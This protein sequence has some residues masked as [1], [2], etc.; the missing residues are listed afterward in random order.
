MN[1]FLAEF[2]ASLAPDVHAV[3]VLD[4]AGWHGA[5]ALSVPANV[6]L[7]PLPPYSPELNPVERIWLHL[8]ETF[9]SRRIFPNREAIIHPCCEAW[10][11]LTAEAG[12]ITSLCLDPWIERLI[13]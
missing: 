7:V 8:R 3:M 4:Q 9:L 5:K 11:A 6:T 2:A 1:L 12:R 10:N 13:S